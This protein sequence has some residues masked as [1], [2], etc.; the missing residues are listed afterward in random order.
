MHSD[1]WSKLPDEKKKLL[2]DNSIS[3]GDPTKK[4]K[5]RPILSSSKVCR[6]MFCLKKK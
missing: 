2:I 4:L 1:S 5:Q 3:V 6:F